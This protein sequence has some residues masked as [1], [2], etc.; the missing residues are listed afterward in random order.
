MP[1]E[2]VI[3]MFQYNRLTL[4][5]PT[6][7]DDP[8]E[9]HWLQALYPDD[10]KRKTNTGKIYGACFTKES[11]SD[12]MWRIYSPSYLG[13]RIK[14]DVAKFIAQLKQIK[15]HSGSIFIGNVKYK[16]DT[17]LIEIS[18]SVKNATHTDDYIIK[19][20]F[21]KRLAFKHE[22]ETRVIYVTHEDDKKNKDIITFDINPRSFVSSML[23]DS[24][25]PDSLSDALLTHLRSVSGMGGNLI[26]QSTLY[27]LPKALRKNP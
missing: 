14:I 12:A 24:R 5:S 3:E 8:F 13:V 25:A 9:K 23:I 11:R 15:N 19:P 1:F 21:N 27:K 20:W 7:W 22:N 26:K 4:V 18:Q 17:D 6:E 16:S 2:F 10:D